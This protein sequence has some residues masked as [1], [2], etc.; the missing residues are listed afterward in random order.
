MG[1]LRIL[2][3][4]TLVVTVAGCTPGATD[5]PPQNKGSGGRGAATGGSDAVVASGTGGSLA[6]GT[7]GVAGT[8]GIVSGSGGNGSGSGGAAVG[9]GGV[10][11][12]G[13]VVSAS[14]GGGTGGRPVA[15]GG[16]AGAG[17]A[18]GGG[19]AAGA[20]GGG[21]GGGGGGGAI[22]GA[23]GLPG[24]TGCG[25][26]P[27]K[28][29]EDFESAEVGGLPAGWMQ[30]EL[31]TTGKPGTVNVQT[32]QFH[33][34]SKSLKSSSDAKDEPRARR[35][36]ASLGT[37]LANNH[38]GRIFYKVQIPAPKPNTY[39]HVT[40]AALTKEP[41]APESRIVDTVQDPTG[42]LQYLYNLPDDTC[43]TMTGFSGAYDA[44]W[45]CAEWYISQATN[46]Y[47]FFQDGKEI[48]ISF[49][50]NTKA[51]IADITYIALGTAFYQ[52]PPSPFVAWI[53]DLAINDTQ[54]GCGP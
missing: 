27:Y 35:S 13:A 4:S 9:T 51:R 11:T 21:K 53:D 28:L 41:A 6:S 39:F 25:T 26:K 24:A 7:G 1:H 12:G 47:R 48:P 22:S 3:M 45:H 36:L 44:N 42:K 18:T 10:E 52:L 15:S 29:C 46:S 38:W 32:D 14:G 34:G 2:A 40:F 54:I 17:G 16:A 8:G 31:Y 50:G 19:S 49:S 5:S 43:C 37:T 23:G 20:A 33:G 30:F